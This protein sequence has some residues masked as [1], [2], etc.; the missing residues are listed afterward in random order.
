MFKPLV[1]RY[2][3]DCRQC[4]LI[5]QLLRDDVYICT[6]EGSLILRDGDAGPE[7][8]SFPV[9]VA[10]MLVSHGP[11]PKWVAALAVY[12]QAVKEDEQVLVWRGEVE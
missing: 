5:G 3:H 10:R 4:N 6:N 9:E 11:D 8:S 1:A 7:Y 12:D 2:R